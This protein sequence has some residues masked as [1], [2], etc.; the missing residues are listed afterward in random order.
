MNKSNDAELD[1]RVRKETY[2]HCDRVHTVERRP[3]AQ[4]V[5]GRE[6]RRGAAEVLLVDESPGLVDDVERMQHL[7]RFLPFAA[8]PV[9]LRFD[10]KMLDSDTNSG[11][12]H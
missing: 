3:E 11:T 4:V 5:V 2:E 7:Q 8:L 9:L 10:T 12:F 1:R 6:L